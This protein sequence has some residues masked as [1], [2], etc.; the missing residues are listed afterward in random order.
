MLGRKSE[1]KRRKIEKK[2]ET[3]TSGGKKKLR[4]KREGKGGGGGIGSE[5]IRRIGAV[6]ER[7]RG[8]SGS[9]LVRPPRRRT[10]SEPPRCH[11]QHL[12]FDWIHKE[13]ESALFLRFL[14]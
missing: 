6:H 7:T 2:K 10:R 1:T 3:L 4:R 13:R 9:G 5:T 12:R 8:Y 11:S 14:P